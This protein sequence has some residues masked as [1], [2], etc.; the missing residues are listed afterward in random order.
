MVGGKLPGFASRAPTIATPEDQGAEARVD[1]AGKVLPVGQ[2]LSA[3]QAL[4]RRGV[5][6]GLRGS[7]RQQ[8]QRLLGRGGN[9][10]FDVP[11]ILFRMLLN[12]D[13]KSTRLNS[14]HLVISY[15]V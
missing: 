13:R 1:A 6:F 3:R 4:A 10:F 7:L 15:A 11:Q 8:A 5:G 2:F 9:R 12:G 14:S